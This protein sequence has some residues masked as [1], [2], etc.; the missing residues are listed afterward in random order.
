MNNIYLVF[1]WLNMKQECIGGLLH[2]EIDQNFVAWPNAA[3]EIGLKDKFYTA[4]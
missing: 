3:N 4:Y 1:I 2:T